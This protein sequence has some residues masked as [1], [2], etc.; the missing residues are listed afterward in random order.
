[1]S[2]KK[3]QGM[4]ASEGRKIKVSTLAELD[5]AISSML[6]TELDTALSF[7][8]I[9][10]Q[11]AVGEVFGSYRKKLDVLVKKAKALPK[12][13]CE[14]D[15]EGDPVIMNGQYIGLGAAYEKAKNDLDDTWEA[16][17]AEE[18]SCPSFPTIP[19]ELFPKKAQGSWAKALKPY[20]SDKRGSD[21]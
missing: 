12:E 9:D 17:M 15:G 16:L 5:T 18:V 21:V 13:Y 2:S 20:L 3:E 4:S 19:K 14:K 1:M 10:L 6:N 11:E 8:L 7:G